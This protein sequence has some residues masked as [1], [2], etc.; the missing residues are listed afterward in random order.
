MKK[1][2]RS[3]YLIALVAS[4]VAA[5]SPALARRAP[6]ADQPQS[7]HSAEKASA[8][9]TAATQ[10]QGL[11]Q[12]VVVTAQHER[13][14]LEQV[15]IAITAVSPQMMRRVHITSLK[16]LQIVTPG[17][18]MATG[19]NY[20]MT[21]IRGVG[22]N[23]S[24]P[25]IENPVAV[26][27]DGAYV[28]RAK[29]GV[30]NIMDP[31]S[32]QVLKG[33]QG[34]L[35][36]MNATG[37]VILIN[38]A[39]PTFQFGGHVMQEVGSQGHR[40]TEAVVNL[41][42]SSTLSTRIA[43][44]YLAN[45][46][47]IRNL[48]DGY[49]FG[50]N[51]DQEFRDKILYRP[52]DNF[53][54]VFEYEYDRIQGSADPEEEFLPN[55]YC[56][57]CAQTGYSHPLA[58][59]YTTNV[60]LLNRGLG[61]DSRNRFSNLRLDYRVGKIDIKNIAAYDDFTSLEVIPADMANVPPT[62]PGALNFVIPSSTSTIT[63]DLT[64][65]SHFGGMIDGLA[66]V[67]YLND[68]STYALYN[69]TKLDPP[70]APPNLAYVHTFVTSPFAEVDIKPL[71]RLTITIGGRYIHVLRRGRRMGEPNS[72]LSESDFTPRF[73][74]S[75]K[76]GH[77]NAYVSYNKGFHAGGMS[78]PAIPM[79][80]F[81]P[82]TLYAYEAGL[83][84]FSGNHRLRANIAIFHYDYH[85]LQTVAINQASKNVG[86]EQNPNAKIWG[87]DG[88]IA[89][90]P[91]NQLE[92]TAGATYLRSH[93]VHFLN[94]G[95]Q[96]PT[97]G[98][99]GNVTGLTTGTANLSGTPLPHAP[100]FTA[101]LTATYSAE[102]W[103][104]WTGELTGSVYHSNWFYFFAGGGGPLGVD[105]QPNFTTVR[106]SGS[107]EPPDGRYKIGFYVDNLTNE[108]TYYLRFTTAPFG[109]LENPNRPRTYGVNVTVNF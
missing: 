65:T 72:H 105:K 25:G 47:Y 38:T 50:W 106:L 4:G 21:Y 100:K 96:V 87:A 108:L 67:D 109:A 60:E 57:L 9:P 34:A 1:L 66:G 49:M 82:E 62:A 12:E 104:Q 30:L 73:V 98:P 27:V 6:V 84:Y 29:G 7:S 53:K 95:V 83:K 8:T 78:T 46:G 44:R 94:A 36:G 51:D 52:T 74:I 42:L 89:W 3:A 31:A 76:F 14:N 41:P 26:Y 39:D 40:E 56:S 58:D 11:L 55:A 45:N 10:G 43:A 13:Q 63:D 17:L 90:R 79:Q 54:A 18:S 91:I 16:D 33:P 23:Y 5:S 22:S 37:G 64:A 75:Y 20:A 103:K 92:L 48:P 2:G 15:P 35:W 70:Y 101:F 77:M 80:V 107:V 88:D 19:A 102:L 93:Y 32:V 97:Y 59:V 81:L 85:Q 69:A 68:L 71:P 24:N 28:E 99:N 86:L 61:V